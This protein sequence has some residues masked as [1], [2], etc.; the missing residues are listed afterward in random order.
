MLTWLWLYSQDE[1][2][3]APREMMENLDGKSLDVW[4]MSAQLSLQPEQFNS[5]REKLTFDLF[6]TFSLG[7]I[8]IQL[9]SYT[10]WYMSTTHTC[11]KYMEYTCN[12]ISM[13]WI[14]MERKNPSWIVPLNRKLIYYYACLMHVSCMTQR[15]IWW[16]IIIN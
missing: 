10:N 9:A 14:E 4:I 16:F 6:E 11:N 7:M 1:E 8:L 5:K 2:E 13:H 15:L 3:A 12:F